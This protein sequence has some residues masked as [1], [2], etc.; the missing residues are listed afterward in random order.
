MT[1]IAEGEELDM[2]PALTGMSSCIKRE[3]SPERYP[4]RIGRD[5]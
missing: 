1:Q 3:C 5:R 4:N 2:D